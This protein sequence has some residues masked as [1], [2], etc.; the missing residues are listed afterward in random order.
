MRTFTE[1]EISFIRNTL[2]PKMFDISDLEF[3][4]P[5]WERVKGKIKPEAVPLFFPSPPFPVEDCDKAIRKNLL[6]LKE[7]LK[8]VKVEEVL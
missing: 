8:K 7:E 3:Y 2:L 5:V 1:E 6:E 4:C